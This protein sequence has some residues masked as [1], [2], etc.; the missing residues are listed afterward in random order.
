[1]TSYELLVESNQESVRA[2][3]AVQGRENPEVRLK[4]NSK[5]K[6]KWGD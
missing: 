1:M 6:M 5:E 2:T 4:L 3:G